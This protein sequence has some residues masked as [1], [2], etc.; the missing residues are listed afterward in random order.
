[1][2]NEQ[3]IDDILKLLRDSVSSDNANTNTEPV[4]EQHIISDEEIEERLKNHYLDQSSDIASTYE[5]QREYEIDSALLTDMDVPEETGEVENIPLEYSEED[6]V[7]DAT[8]IIF[9][10]DDASAEDEL[11]VEEPSDADVEEN[12]VVTE[13]NDDQIV[14]EEIV[15]DSTEDFYDEED[16]YEE[17][18]F[19]D[20][21][22]DTSDVAELDEAEAEE[23]EP[24]P[25]PQHHETFLASM[26]KTGIGFTTDEIY[27]SDHDQEV[28]VAQVE[29]TAIQVPEVKIEIEDEAPIQDEPVIAEDIDMSTI[30]LM[31]QFCEKEELEDA[32]GDEKLEEFL[33][34]EQTEEV[35]HSIPK[36]VLD[37]REYV[38]EE[39]NEAIIA[40]YQ[41]KRFSAMWS[42]IGCALIA[43]IAFVYELLP[44]LDVNIDG[45]LDYNRNPAVYALIGLQ[46]V[47]FAAVICYKRLWIGLKR[48][49]SLS[50]N[51][52]SIVAIILALTVIYDI[53]IV[54]MLSFTGDDMPPMY[55]GIATIIT[56]IVA[57][58]DYLNVVSEEKAFGVYSASTGKYTLM[59][60]TV[61]TSIGAKMY[62][63]GLDPTKTVYSARSVD[64][65][66]GFFR[67][68]NENG[69][70]DAVLT[71]SIIPVIIIGMIAA[72][73]SV[74]FEADAYSSCASFMLALYAILP[75][76]MLFTDSVSGTVASVR[77][78]KR[79]SAVAGR[80]AANAYSECNIMVFGDTH[81]FK[82]CKTD[83]VGFAIYDT[84]TGYLALG[85]LD[86]LF[87]H[88]GGPLSGLKMDSLPDVFK[89]KKVH[90]K[91]TA[92]N[93]VEAIVENKHSIIVGDH[94]F[95]RRYGLEFPQ[96]ET[97]NG[98]STL[99]VSLNGKVTAKLSVRYQVEPVFEMIIERLYAEG[100]AVAI[101]TADPLINSK[102]VAASR[103]LGT[104]P[105]SVIHLG[106]DDI[107]AKQGN[108]REDADGIVSCQSRLK[109]AEV[110]VWLKRL[111]RIRKVSGIVA[112]CF[113]AVGFLALS[114]FVIFGVASAVHQLYVLLFLLLELCAMSAVMIALLPPR[115]YFT[116]DLLYTELEQSHM[117]E[118]SNKKTQEK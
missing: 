66:R 110:L 25:E 19:S 54:I 16:N 113:S 52:H 5:P 29:E 57:L 46:F 2:N 109:L 49:F 101:R 63:G 62:G 53:I 24:S 59:R 43:L 10:E 4:Y 78:A 61:N 105:V 100:I 23:E 44:I 89:F 115:D 30:N 112:M 74:V 26:R 92:R 36:N 18:V 7:Q 32:I 50:P 51:A 75:M 85:C 27:K 107:D 77:L 116:V 55:N 72:I 67:S 86:A 58:A 3:N 12:A 17:I 15:A 99:C 97:E 41:K 39:Q 94:D 9:E 69:R 47:V 106:V 80:E 104:S 28:A 40:S 20:D 38:S 33:I 34:Y 68:M 83:E 6:R 65:P 22:L 45:V 35:E 82:K 95:M 21:E 1:M 96:N 91:R 87:N 71:A 48:A 103:T 13:E 93:G 56:C 90:I 11:Y 31:R 60:E 118:Q 14:A 37:G 81:L 64:F 114:F 102:M 84:K 98:R 70:K 73:F 117:Q 79:G 42:M 8:D 108:Y 111:K 88:I 76:A